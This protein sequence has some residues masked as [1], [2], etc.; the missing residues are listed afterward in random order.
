VICEACHG[1]GFT[2]VAGMVVPCGECGGSG[3]AHCCEGER[4]VPEPDHA[5]NG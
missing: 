3:I 4:P 5:L 2:L 1:D